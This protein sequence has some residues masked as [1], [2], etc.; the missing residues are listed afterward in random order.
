M[1]AAGGRKLLWL[2]SQRIASHR[3]DIEP[4]T[5]GAAAVAVALKLIRQTGRLASGDP[6]ERIPIDSSRP[7]SAGRKFARSSLLLLCPC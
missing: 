3:I 1:A 2:P 5:N 4:A 6:L 7:E